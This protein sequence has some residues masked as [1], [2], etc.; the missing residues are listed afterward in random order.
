[1]YSTIT[2]TNYDSCKRCNY[3]TPIITAAIPTLLSFIKQGTTVASRNNG[4]VVL[5]SI[6]RLVR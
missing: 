6:L 3:S 4:E 5:A 1:V 2:A